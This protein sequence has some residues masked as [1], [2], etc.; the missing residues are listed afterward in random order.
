MGISIF[1]VSK[2]SIFEGVNIEKKCTV[3]NATARQNTQ[4]TRQ[5]RDSK[6]SFIS[7]KRCK[8]LIINYLFFNILKIKKFITQKTRRSNATEKTIAK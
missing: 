7:N 6:W 4:K 5:K 3:A 2:E 1:P 8:Y